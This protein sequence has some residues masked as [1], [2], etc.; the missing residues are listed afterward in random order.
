[1]KATLK[2]GTQMEVKTGPEW[3]TVWGLQMLDPDGFGERTK[4]APRYSAL[5]DEDT[6]LRCIGKCTCK[7]NRDGKYVKMMQ[8][9]WNKENAD[10]TTTKAELVKTIDA[11][12]KKGKRFDAT[13]EGGK[14]NAKF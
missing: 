11:E 13:T 9:H 5:M 14:H 8:E 4:D 7:F 6:Y 12:I 3:D 10:I 1:M 2:D